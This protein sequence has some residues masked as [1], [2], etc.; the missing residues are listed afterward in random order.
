MGGTVGDYDGDGFDDLFVTGLDRTNLFQNRGDGT[1][2][3]VTERAGVASSRW[4]TAAGFGDLDGDGDLDLVAITYVECR[5]TEVFS[6]PDQVGR[7]IHC[8]P[9][10]FPAQLDH[11]FRN[12]G[13]GTFTDVSRDSGIEVPNGRGLG[14]AI[15]DL[16][17]DGRLDLFVANDASANRLFRNLGGLRFAEVGES[18][19]VAYD[20]SGRATASMGVVAEDLDGDGRI[21]LFHTNFIN[22]SCTLHRNLG[23]GLF[24]DAT[25]AAGLD[26]PTRPKTGFGAVA[27]DVQ[28]DGRLDLLL[29]NG[30]VDDRPWANSPMA[31]TAQL[32]LGQD[33]G[34][35]RLISTRSAPYFA[36]PVVGRGAAAGDLDND[37][38]A[39]VVVVHRDVPAALLRNH[40]PGGHAIGLHLVGTTSSRTPIG[41][42]IRVRAGGHEAV[43]WLTSG[44]GY[45]GANDGRLWF[46]LGL[47]RNTGEVEVRWPSGA[48]ERWRDLPADRIHLLREGASPGVALRLDTDVMIAP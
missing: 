14:L 24:A 38:R 8:S 22:E 13:D 27:L 37:G 6:C 46:G 1:F 4:T 3:D 48:V 11:L 45:L 31:Q 44:T 5:P 32:F 42:R 20:G 47:E 36:R 9:G 39:D 17:D 30:A 41:A 43:R 7:P 40:T 18:A 21:D 16:D 34:R 19:G 26:A 23:G 12:N 28:N 35:F 33:A 2:E 10:R 25:L 15:A 29:A